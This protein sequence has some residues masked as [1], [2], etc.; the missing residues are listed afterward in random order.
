[1]V[2]CDGVACDGVLCEGASG[3]RCSVEFVVE[4]WAAAG[5]LIASTIDTTPIMPVMATSQR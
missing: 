4:L 5:K 3:G 1:M 2:D